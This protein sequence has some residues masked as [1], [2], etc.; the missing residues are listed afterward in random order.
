MAVLRTFRR[1]VLRT[2]RR[3]WRR[4]LARPLGLALL[5]G[6]VPLASCF[7]PAQTA[8][9]PLVGVLAYVATLAAAVGLF[10]LINQAGAGLTAA[11]AAAAAPESPGARWFPASR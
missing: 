9:F 5:L 1:T 3:S 10:L 6:I 4:R 2:F 8:A 7:N 11:G